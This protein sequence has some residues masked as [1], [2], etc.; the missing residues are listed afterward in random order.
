MCIRDSG[1]EAALS[2]IKAATTVI[3]I[4][5]DCLFPA[6]CMKEWASLIPGADFRVI[7]SVF[8]HDGFLLESGQIVAILSEML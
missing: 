8:G 1:V 4:D 5:S 6:R 2:R 3:G 7:T